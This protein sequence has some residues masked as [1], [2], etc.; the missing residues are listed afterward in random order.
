[1]QWYLFVLKQYAVFKGRA[2]RPEYWYFVLCNII[3]SV[4]LAIVNHILGNPGGGEGGG[5]LGFVYS[6]MVLL[7]SLAVATRR[8]HDTGRTGWWLLIGLIPLI[9]FLVLVYFFVQPTEPEANQYGDMPPASP[10]L[11]A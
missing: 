5:V 2:S 1:M 8:L 10:V 4:V 7:P 9:G 3:I 6:L 11:S